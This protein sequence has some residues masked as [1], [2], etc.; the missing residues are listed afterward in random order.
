MDGFA[1]GDTDDR[2]NESPVMNLGLQSYLRF[3]GG[4]EVGAMFGSSHTEPEE[5]R[6]EP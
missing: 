5:V 6:L 4:T 3:E 1:D 2:A